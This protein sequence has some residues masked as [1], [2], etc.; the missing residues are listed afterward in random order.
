MDSIE[1]M[2]KWSILRIEILA[3]KIMWTYQNDDKNPRQWMY[4]AK[5]PSMMVIKELFCLDWNLEIQE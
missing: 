5:Y 3:L 1:T 2:Y 4:F